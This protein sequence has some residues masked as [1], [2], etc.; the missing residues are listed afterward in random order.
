MDELTRFT[1]PELWRQAP[2][3]MTLEEAAGGKQG[4]LGPP[5]PEPRSVELVFRVA[6][7]RPATSKTIDEL[8]EYLTPRQVAHLLGIDEKTVTRWSLSDTSMPVLRR[9]RVVRFHR[10]RLMEWLQRQ[11]PHGARRA[12]R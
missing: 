3:W 6:A 10:D 2:P 12:A 8:P 11:E 4:E 1:T 9:G 7:P 5:K